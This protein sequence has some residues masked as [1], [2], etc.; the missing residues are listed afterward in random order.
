T[1]DE[2]WRQRRSIVV[3]FRHSAGT[4]EFIDSHPL[5]WSS[6]RIHAPCLPPVASA[7]ELKTKLEGL[8][9]GMP[10]AYRS[11]LFVLPGVLTPEA[12]A[13]SGDPGGGRRALAHA[14]TGSVATWVAEREAARAAGGPQAKLN[15]VMVDHYDLARP[16]RPENLVYQ[17]KRINLLRT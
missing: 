6:A 11:R 1:C 8:I 13:V 4:T 15:I 3:I 16:D 14:A 5:V 10:A 17:A 7:P 12:G 9:D 2:L